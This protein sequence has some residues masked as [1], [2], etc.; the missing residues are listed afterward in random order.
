MIDRLTRFMDNPHATIRSTG[1]GGDHVTK[2]LR[3]NLA[4][5]TCRYQQTTWRETAQCQ[6]VET[7]VRS[8]SDLDML[9][10]PCKTRWIEDDHV[11]LLALVSVAC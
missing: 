9:S 4:G 1:S 2:H 8:Y 10:R 11:E 6:L 5:T 3:P 7:C